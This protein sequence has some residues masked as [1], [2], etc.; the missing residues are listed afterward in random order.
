M[1][2]HAGV[3]LTT[4]SNQDLIRAIFAAKDVPLTLIPRIAEY[5]DFHEPDWPAVMQSVSEPIQPFG[6]YFDFVVAIT[7]GL[8]ALWYE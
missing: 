6:F 7:D 8:K 3:D 4:A 1:V 5:R 2:T